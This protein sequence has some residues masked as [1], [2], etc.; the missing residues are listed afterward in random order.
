MQQLTFLAPGKFE[1]RDVPA[2]KPDAD[3]DAIVAPIA[4]VR[5]VLCLVYTSDAAHD[6]SGVV[7]AVTHV[8]IKK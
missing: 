5:C 8:I 1:W 6:E 3:T 2:P 4:V 7:P